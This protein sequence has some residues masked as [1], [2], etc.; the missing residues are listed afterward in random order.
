MVTGEVVGK[1]IGVEELT[2]EQAFNP[3]DETALARIASSDLIRKFLAHYYQ[4]SIETLSLRSQ[5]TFYLAT[6]QEV[7][8]LT[9]LNDEVAQKSVASQIPAENG[10]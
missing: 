9:L 2:F 8:F 5:E 6:A 3:V 7:V 1:F 4:Q 10:V